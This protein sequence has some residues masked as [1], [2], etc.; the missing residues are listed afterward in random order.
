MIEFLIFIPVAVALVSAIILVL[1]VGFSLVWLDHQ[2]SEYIVCRSVELQNKT[3]AEDCWNHFRNQ[4]E[5]KNIL[6]KLRIDEESLSR[7]RRLSFE[8]TAKDGPS[9]IP[10]KIQIQDIK[11]QPEF[12]IKVVKASY[13]D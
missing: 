12:Q 10:L 1:G 4:T 3:Q 13:L 7:L 5:Q 2:A 11:W 9:L 6:M 8:S